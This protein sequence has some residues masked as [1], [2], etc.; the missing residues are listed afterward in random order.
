VAQQLG[1]F[2]PPYCGRRRR[3]D[4]FT[5]AH[6]LDQVAVPDAVV[7]GRL[8]VGKVG[9]GAIAGLTITSNI[10][11]SLVIDKFGLFAWKRML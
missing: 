7:T 8:F 4:L 2:P 6:A 9:A 10:L 11:M 5:Q 3:L 1:V